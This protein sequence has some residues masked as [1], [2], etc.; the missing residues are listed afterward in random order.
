MNAPGLK[1]SWSCTKSQESLT[2]NNTSETKKKEPEL[3]CFELPS[4]FK[5]TS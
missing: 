5:G 1:D 3:K 2:S 4:K